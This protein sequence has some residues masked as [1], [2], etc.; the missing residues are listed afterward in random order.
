MSI[1]EKNSSTLPIKVI[2]ELTRSLDISKAM[3]D[4][5]EK[6]YKAIAKWLAGSSNYFLQDADIYSQ[7]SI[8]LGTVVR[9]YKYD[10]FD[11]DLV[12]NLPYCS[13]DMDSEY[14]HKII[15]D[16]LKEHDTYKNMIEP[17][18]RGWRINYAGDFHLDITPAIDN[19]I[20]YAENP[21]YANTAEL[22]PDK[23]LKN[24]KDSN[25]RGYA[26]W[27]DESDKIVL[28][29][30]L[31]ELNERKMF[32]KDAT[33]EELPAY[34]KFK[35]ALKKSVQIL[36]RDRDVYFNEKAKE[37]KEYMPISIIITTLA[38]KSYRYLAEQKKTYINPIDLIIDIVT[39]MDC[40]INEVNG[41]KYL[42]NPTN[43]KEN[44]CE[45]WNTSKLYEKT[46]KLWQNQV[47]RKLIA[48][49]EIK[50]LDQVKKNIQESYG[51]K[52]SKKVIDSLN[53]EVSNNRELGI[54]APTII[55]STL[56]ANSV[57]DNNFYGI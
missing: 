41:E 34:N 38:A 29:F 1:I 10:E 9:P 36:K 45:K 49:K 28:N 27:F 6:K 47:I 15:G 11:I 8:K 55:T 19:F 39:Y 18:K 51:E 40:F 30:L 42:A 32:A 52:Y 20:T 2:D 3:Y 43:G 31:T 33:I 21:E 37:F 5:A 35:G 53:K 46:F 57:K 22:V 50:G 14:V 44:F 7:G 4:D 16:R 23:K 25:P 17:L 26:F 13:K 56:N 54:L 48:F 24:W 12:V